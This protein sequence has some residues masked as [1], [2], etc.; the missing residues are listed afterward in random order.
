LR[1]AQDF[2][3]ELTAG[4]HVPDHERPV[5]VAEEQQAHPERDDHQRDVAKDEL[6]PVLGAG[7]KTKFEV[8]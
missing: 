6:Q 4:L 7:G 2:C 5:A 8:G 3:V 1:L